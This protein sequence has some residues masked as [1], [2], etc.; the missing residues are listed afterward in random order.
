VFVLLTIRK[1]VCTIIEAHVIAVV[2]KNLEKSPE[3]LIGKKAAIR[4]NQ[5]V[6][7]VDLEVYTLL[8]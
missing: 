5:C 1:M 2:G 8:R 6:I 3:L 4:K 7:C